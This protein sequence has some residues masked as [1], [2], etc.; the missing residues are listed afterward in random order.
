MSIQCTF[1]AAVHTAAFFMA[2]AFAPA[3]AGAFHV[4]PVRIEMSAKGTSSAMTVSNNGP[5]AVVIQL[6]RALWTQ[7]N[8]VDKYSP[9]D[10][11]IATPPIFTVQPGGNQ[12]VRIGLRRR[13][14]P[15]TELSYRLYI[16]EVPPAKKEGFKGLQMALRISIPVFVEPNIK[17]KPGLR[18]SAQ[19]SAADKLTVMLK[20]DSQAHVQVSDFRVNLPGQD[21]PLAVQQVSAYLLPLQSRS[22]TMAID[23]AKPLKGTALR[24]KAFT[25]AGEMEADVILDRP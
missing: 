7:E 1:L 11:L 22:W 20:N 12:V 6:H 5:A 9:T 18:F 23:P 24:V 13:P 8:G 15:T 4:A 19:K 25:D 21:V 16:Q 10:D 2:G 14:D 17:A 3:Y